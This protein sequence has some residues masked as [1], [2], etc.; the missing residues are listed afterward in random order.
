MPCFIFTIAE[1]SSLIAT[2]AWNAVR[3]P[4]IAR[5]MPSLSLPVSAV[6]QD[7]STGRLGA[8]AIVVALKT[9]AANHHLST[10]TEFSREKSIFALA[11]I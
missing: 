1:P 11:R 4:A 10:K 9:R 2:P 8:K 7:C 3:A 5:W 6:S